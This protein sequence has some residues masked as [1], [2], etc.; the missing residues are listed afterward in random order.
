MHHTSRRDDEGSKADRAVR[1]G[2]RA[3]A[4]FLGRESL[5]V[6]A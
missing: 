1:D 3:V 2:R 6:P 5:K 4:D